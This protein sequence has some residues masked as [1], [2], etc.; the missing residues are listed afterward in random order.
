MSCICSKMLGY[1][2]VMRIILQQSYDVPLLTTNHLIHLAMLK[3]ILN[4]MVN[5]V[6]RAFF[7]KSMKSTAL[8][9]NYSYFKVCH[10]GL[11]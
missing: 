1:R 2:K 5:P 8:L 7:G 3:H 9:Q 6:V 4:I 10:R 11:I